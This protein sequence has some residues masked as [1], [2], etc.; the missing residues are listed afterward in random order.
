MAQT[1]AEQ[2][3]ATLASAGVRRIYGIAGDSL[4]QSQ[5]LTER[6]A[7]LFER[8]DVAALAD[9]LLG[10]EGYLPAFLPAAAYRRFGREL[11]L[12]RLRAEVA[13]HVEAPNGVGS[14]RI[15][16]RTRRTISLA[17]YAIL[18]PVADVYAPFLDGPLFDFLSSLPARL[19]LDRS[20]HTDAIKI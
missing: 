11:A 19:L 6:R 17:P 18:A 14:F 5:F 3:I 4:S 15:W 13:R 20:L 10:P 9:D 7:E 16:N 2:L 12:D 8:G 1:V